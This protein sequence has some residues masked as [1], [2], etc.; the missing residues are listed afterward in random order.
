MVLIFKDAQEAPM[1]IGDYFEEEVT[2]QDRS[3]NEIEMTSL[4]EGIR[5]LGQR[6]VKAV[7]RISTQIIKA[8]NKFGMG[9]N[10]PKEKK[11]IILNLKRVINSLKR[12]KWTVYTSGFDG[13]YFEDRNGVLFACKTDTNGQKKYKSI[14]LF[15]GPTMDSYE[16]AIQNTIDDSINIEDEFI[17]E[18]QSISEI[19]VS[20][21][22]KN[23]EFGF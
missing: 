7:K 20:G 15:E 13:L 4:E 23:T 16:E 22:Y 10:N 9:I 18:L 19:E 17:K 6:A 2:Y 5:N 21:E 8:R 3:A 1:E 14:Y 11:T 12:N